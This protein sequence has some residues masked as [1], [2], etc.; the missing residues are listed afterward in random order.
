MEN[1]AKITQEFTKAVKHLNTDIKNMPKS[2]HSSKRSSR[3]SS[4]LSSRADTINS[5]PEQQEK[6]E[7]I[8]NLLEQNIMPNVML[9]ASNAREIGRC[10]IKVIPVTE[11]EIPIIMLGNQQNCIKVSL[12]DNDSDSQTKEH[13]RLSETEFIQQVESYKEV[14]Q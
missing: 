2:V 3:H 7:E 13:K 8:R 10:I 11:S 9:N 12:I 4:R 14:Y 1:F 6:A 5:S